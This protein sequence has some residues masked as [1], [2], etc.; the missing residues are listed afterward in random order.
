VRRQAPQQRECREFLKLRAT[1][2]PLP[3][4]VVSVRSKRRKQTV[5]Q[6]AQLSKSQSDL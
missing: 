3:H 6:I 1:A 5:S 4:L 2:G